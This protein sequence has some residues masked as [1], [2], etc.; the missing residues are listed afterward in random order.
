MK[1]LFDFATK[2]LSQDAMICWL[3]SNYDNKEN[4][5]LKE[6]A[7]KFISFI[8]GKNYAV[9]EI[10]HLNILQQANNMDVIID[11]W[12]TEKA[13]YQDTSTSDYVIVIED[14]TTS[15]AH[16]DQLLNYGKKADEWESDNKIIRK[17]FYKSNYLSW[18]DVVE[19]NKYIFKDKEFKNIEY[20][21][22]ALKHSYVWNH[23]DIENYNK[24][25]NKAWQVYDI[26]SICGFFK[27]KVI[28]DEIV[29]FYIKHIN[30]IRKELLEINENT[31][32][33][34]FRNWKCFVNNVIRPYCQE[35]NKDV[36][37]WD[38]TWVNKYATAGIVFN[39]SISNYKVILELLF[40][41]YQ[42]HIHGIIHPHFTIDGKT[43]WEYSNNEEKDY[44]TNILKPLVKN[45]SHQFKVKNS[46]RSIA[47][48]NHKDIRRDLCYDEFVDKIKGMID[49]FYETFKEIII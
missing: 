20:N 28:D 44:V 26:D 36:D 34:N 40:R 9:G 22:W 29:N 12:E 32:D 31:I 13:N 16:D 35:L 48:L 33:W 43:E 41:P 6:L 39:T 45:N 47:S 37:V 18:K 8:S 25:Y 24:L 38:G 19:I 27:D 42:K 1:N 21:D 5:A 3:V 11:I 17:V 7:Y 49:D 30:E 46:D 14:K 4:Q 10:K 2:E 23:A 15:S